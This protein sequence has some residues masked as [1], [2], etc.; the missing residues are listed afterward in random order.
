MYYIVGLG[1]PGE[2]Y[3]NTRHN[4]GWLL[5]DACIDALGLPT[6]HQSSK[7]SG[8]VSEG[9]VEGTEVTCLYP[10][11]FMNH[12]GTAVAKLVPQNEAAQL[13]VLYDDIDLPFGEVK[14][15]FG[16]G[17]GGHNGIKSIASSLGTKDFVRVR[18][19]IASATVWPWES[20]A[21]R[22]P[23][24]DALASYVLGTLTKKEAAVVA[25]MAT[26]VP[27]LVATIIRDGK[28]VAMQE[29]N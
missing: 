28:E 4:T 19:G 11:T 18:I 20:G 17:D 14:V 13:I 7:L 16:R 12:S 2:K 25:D 9:V 29:Y 5:L 10:D 26:W 23:K 6:P 27:N 21:V 1:N 8:R 22:R 24:G 15:S 3:K